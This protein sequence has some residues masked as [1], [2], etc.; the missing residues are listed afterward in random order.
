MRYKVIMLGTSPGSKGG[1]ASVVEM[2][3]K[4]EFCRQWAVC[5]VPTHQDGSFSR[6]FI[7]LC[8]AAIRF[9]FVL[10]TQDIRLVHAHTASRRSFFRKSLFFFMCRLARV[11]YFIHLHGAQFLAFYQFECSWFSRWLVRSFFGHAA[12]VLVLSATWA[13]A[14]QPFSGLAPCYVVPNPVRF[15]AVQPG[16]R[17]GLTLFFSGRLGRRKGIFDLLVAFAHV[18]KTV[19]TARLI[20]CGD[21]QVAECRQQV[22]ILGLSQHVDIPGWVEG[23][24]LQ[25]Y[26]AQADIFVLPSYDEGLPMS[27][28]E[29]MAAELAVVTTPVGG[30]PDL[31]E[32]RAN[33]FL[34]EPGDIDGLV[35]RLITLLTNPELCLAV[36]GKARE[37]VM[38]RFSSEQVLGRVEE[39]YRQFGLES[40]L[41]AGA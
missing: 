10:W 18:I 36:G 19:P 34:V 28:L 8:K 41:E 25:Q 17:N 14:V 39:V 5:F 12:A 7:V 31:I 15:S 4:K 27:L 29:A 21:G 32:D 37:T 40:R 24:I 38:Q 30:I 26:L 23:D 20:C 33:G 9:L 2:Y 22:E 11:P 13:D 6:K 1:V 35:A 3:Q 16:I